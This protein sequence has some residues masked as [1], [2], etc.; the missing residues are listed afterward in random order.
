MT[1][2]VVIHSQLVEKLPQA[3]KLWY[4]C[5]AMDTKGSGK[6]VLHI[7]QIME[8]LQVGRTTVWR[9]YT[10]NLF[11]KIM[12]R[13]DLLTLYYKGI[14]PLCVEY[15]ISHWGA[16]T[17]IN[18]EDLHNVK[19]FSTLAETL[20]MQ[21]RSRYLANKEKRNK[22]AE[23]L[24]KRRAPKGS[25]SPALSDSKLDSV[26]TSEQSISEI[27]LG[28]MKKEYG[29]LFVNETWTPFGTS[30][31][32]VANILSKSLKTISRRLRL[33]NKIKVAYTTTQTPHEYNH[34]QFKDS[35]DWSNLAAR[36][37]INNGIVFKRMVSLY[38]PTLSLTTK[39]YSLSK[40]KKKFVKES[41]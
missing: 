3:V 7:S 30:Q 17:E 1:Q 23:S 28:I 15:N 18:V 22:V 27:S 16:S 19:Y 6:V 4:L 9:Y 8:V 13:G 24:N 37:F 12:K 10:S 40:L 26:F 25:F 31:S 2:S 14:I 21:A 20:S 36:Y 11:T 41:V 34:Y 29:T 5:R 38:Q 33:A 35:E 39:K 32:T